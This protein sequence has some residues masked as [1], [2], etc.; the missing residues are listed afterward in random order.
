MS[1][2]G[3][4]KKQ[5]NR[6][7]AVGDLARDVA[8]DPDAPRSYRSMKRYLINLPQDISPGLMPTLERSW[9]EFEKSHPPCAEG[10]RQPP[11]REAAGVPAGK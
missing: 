7:D 11:A 5:V 2:L 10:V 4:M 6:N 8:A 1:F 3:W 9:K